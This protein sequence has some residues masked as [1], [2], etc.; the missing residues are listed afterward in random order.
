MIAF[1][2]QAGFA[3]TLDQA[4]RDL[5][6]YENSRGDQLQPKWSEWVKKD[7][8]ELMLSQERT[9]K[10]FHSQNTTLR[11]VAASLAAEHWQ[12]IELF[13]QDVL[14]LAFDDPDSA[15][16]GAALTALGF[17]MGYISDPTGFLENLLQELFPA[18]HSFLDYARNLAIRV[19]KDTQRMWEDLGGS[20]IPHMLENR[21]AAE[22]Y[23]KHSDSNLRAAA[24][25]VLNDYWEPD[26]KFVETCERM[27]FQDS[28]LKVRQLALSMLT[29]NFHGT[30]DV[31]IGRLTASIVYDSSVPVDLR[32][33]A[34]RSLFTIR[35]VALDKFGAVHSRC[36]RF[37]DD[38]DWAF[39][40]SFL[41]ESQTG[42]RQ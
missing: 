12:G 1:T 33:T 3:A 38:V 7:L 8:P 10:L 16:R 41:K 42:F 29:C 5:R 26:E 39:V 30:D 23:L 11:L 27:V 17:H 21:G 34:Y 14:R 40:D 9:A 28:D 37:P 36:F 25:F 19:R 31:R 13:A 18:R 32:L 2:P 4:Q 24:L 22:I 35:R 6:N 20:H 15:G